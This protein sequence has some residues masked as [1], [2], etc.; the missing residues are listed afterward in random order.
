MERDRIRERVVGSVERPGFAALGTALAPYR[1]GI[2]IA[3]VHGAVA[4][5]VCAGGDPAGSDWLQVLELH[6]EVDRA[7]SGARD[8]LAALAQSLRE[9]LAAQP[10]GLTPLLAEDAAGTEQRALGLIEWCR[11]FL[12]G[13]GLA[14]ADAARTRQEVAEVLHDFA[15]IAATEPDFGAEAEDAAALAEL[16]AH[17][18]FGAVLLHALLSAPPDATL[19]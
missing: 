3:E 9:D 13:F 18:R 15:D 16:E 6:G 4:G 10:P 8:T 11:G 7:A 12:G 17:V 2:S 19:Q 1:L 14:G 5:F